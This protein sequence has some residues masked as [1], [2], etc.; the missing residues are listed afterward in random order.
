MWVFL[1]R[2]KFGELKTKEANIVR[3][4]KSQSPR[5]LEHIRKLAPENVVKKIYDWK[6]MRSEEDQGNNR[7]T[8]IKRTCMR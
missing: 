4:L 8:I 7:V 1:R 2:V 6:E 5:W 3:F